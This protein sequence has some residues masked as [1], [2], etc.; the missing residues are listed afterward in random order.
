MAEVP[1]NKDLIPYNN[2]FAAKSSL[3]QQQEEKK[4]MPKM[5]GDISI[6]GQAIVRRK[7][8]GQRFTSMFLNNTDLKTVFDTIATEIIVPG[9]KEMFFNGFTDTISMLLWGEPRSTP[10]RGYRNGGGIVRD[11][12]SY[13]NNSSL[14]NRYRNR[15]DPV[16]TGSVGGTRYFDILY[17]S[18]AAAHSVLGSMRAYINKYQS[19]PVVALC[20][21]IK[22]ETGIQLDMTHIDADRGW[23]DLTGIDVMPRYG[24]WVLT[25]TD[26]IPLESDEY[27][28]KR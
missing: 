22:E 16:P 15:P 1:M 28:V 21:F 14:N 23:T 18:S 13:S 5:E 24:G 17:T 10:T 9:L 3:A 6:R 25:Y 7:T 19:L 2:S 11:Y 12:S 26:P 27:R 20:D 8:P 4:E